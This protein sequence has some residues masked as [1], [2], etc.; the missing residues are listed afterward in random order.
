ML[1]KLQVGDRVRHPASKR[2]GYV[3]Q[4]TNG[5]TRLHA[6]LNGWPHG[7]IDNI[8]AFERLPKRASK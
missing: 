8:D 7:L 4:I 6:D 3:V 5:G 1:R 2:A